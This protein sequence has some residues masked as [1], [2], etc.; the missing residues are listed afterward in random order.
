[1]DQNSTAFILDGLDVEAIGRYTDRIQ[2]SCP[3]SPWT[4]ESGKDSNPSMSIRTG[5]DVSLYHCFAC[6]E[7][8][9]LS[10]LVQ[11][12]GHYRCKDYPELYE[13]AKKDDDDMERMVENKFRDFDLDQKKAR[14][15]QTRK[16]ALIWSEDE[17]KPFMGKV[18]KYALNRGLSIEI[19]KD[20]EL[21]YDERLKVEGR[22]SKRLVFP[23]RDISGN[24]VGMVG[25]AIAENDHP[26]YYNY[27][28]FPKSM[29]LYGEHKIDLEYEN[30]FVVEG[31]IDVAKMR[32]M[33]FKNVVGLMGR[34]L[35]D[36]QAD[37]IQ[38]WDRLTHII[39]DG[40]LYGRKGTEKAVEKLKKREVRMKI[41][42]LP[43]GQDPGSAEE[44]TLKELIEGAKFLL[45]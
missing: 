9:T 10:M 23:I 27:F 6:G 26:K 21:G 11:K 42:A 3:F 5:D 17:I 14:Q 44:D 30:L 39:F 41:V 34:S 36:E 25:R 31:M 33:G 1:M 13:V 4:H 8:G 28:N 2:V 7:A 12:L 19:C 37:K 29:F 32:Q 20:L 40:D 18:P 43:D 24:L 38:A 15:A 22:V 45:V 35:S 16:K